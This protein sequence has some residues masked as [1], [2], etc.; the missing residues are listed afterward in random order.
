MKFQHT[1]VLLLEGIEALNVSRGK[2]YI[3]A[4]IGGGGHANLILEGGGLV[5]GIDQDE[6]ALEYVHEEQI[7]R[8]KKKK[9][10]LVRGN[11]RDVK[12]LAHEN[13]FD[14]V[15]GILFDLGVSS[16]QLNAVER[17]FSIR[18]DARLDMRM[19]RQGGLSAYEI[20][21]R[22]PYQR[23]VEIF[24][25]YGEEHNASE[26]AREIVDRRRN[27]KIETTGELARMIERIRHK[28]EHIHPATRVF[29]ALRI[30]TN[31]EL[32]SLREALVDSLTLLKSSGRIVAISFHSLED[33]IVKQTFEQF[34]RKNMGEIIT[35][36][37]LTATFEEKK[38]NI[39]ARSAK[40]RV[41]EK[42]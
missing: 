36:K 37:P 25:K 34:K 16:H 32:S 33:R 29:Q 8:I 38:K 21:N 26:I 9:L 35:K 7:E 40:L 3:D 12:K 42:N 10:I 1:P 2:K 13:K 30:E 5:L 23:L 17:G 20:V 41:F 14:K 22:Y 27:K 28:S 4:T 11:F 18:H 24:H 39:R 6:E 15:D 31:D 19:D